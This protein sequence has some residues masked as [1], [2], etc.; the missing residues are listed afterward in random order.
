[1]DHCEVAVELYLMIEEEVVVVSCWCLLRG[2]GP[3]AQGGGWLSSDFV[4]G[5]E[6]GE[7]RLEV[8]GVLNA[9]ELSRR[10]PPR[11]GQRVEAL[12][13]G[14]IGTAFAWIAE[15]AQVHHLEIVRHHV[16]APYD[17]GHSSIRLLGV[18]DRPES[19]SA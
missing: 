14:T 16:K 19:Q 13:V 11:R 6:L 9:V 18:D 3:K 15:L 2:V 1:M 12:E 17:Q 8:V 7:A 10:W 5:D 4:G